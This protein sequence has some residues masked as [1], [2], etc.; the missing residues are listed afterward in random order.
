MRRRVRS[1]VYPGILII[2]DD[3]CGLSLYWNAAMIKGLI[4]LF[5]RVA[6]F[7]VFHFFKLFI[8]IP[9]VATLPGPPPRIFHPFTSPPL[10]L[11]GVPPLTHPP[12]A[13]P[14]QNPPS[15]GH[16]V[17]TGLRVSSPEKI[18]QGSPLPNM[19]QGPQ[20]SPGMLFGWWLSLWELPGVRVSWHCWSSNG[21]AISP[22]QL[23]QS[24]S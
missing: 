8:Y 18:R 22:L 20:T 12:P 9:N 23:I 24:F 11:R 6:L 2:T 5:Y 3:N 1:Q 10:L 13:H 21:A 16:Q 15:L 19:C 4:C 7:L 14:H 17:S